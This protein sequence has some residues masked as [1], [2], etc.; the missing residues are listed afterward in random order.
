[1]FLAG[2]HEPVVKLGMHRKGTLD[3]HVYLAVATLN[4]GDME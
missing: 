3:F 1:M 2:W 4:E